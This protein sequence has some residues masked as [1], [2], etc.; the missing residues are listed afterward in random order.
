MRIVWL[1]LAARELLGQDIVFGTVEPAVVEQRFDRLQLKN[2]QRAAVLREIF[3]EAGCTAERWS[4]Q[5]IDSA[6]RPNL[7]CTL[8]GTTDRRVVVSAHYDKVSTGEG[9][10]D[11]WSGASLLPSLFQA[12]STVPRSHTFVFLLTSDEE[13]GLIGSKEF[14]R[15]LTKEQLRTMD[16]DVNIDSID[17]AGPTNVWVSRA[18][19]TLF[20]AAMS[21]AA[22]LGLPM[23]GVNVD[24]G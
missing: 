8:P 10:I 14:V 19:K 6:K 22:A 15:H 4:E 21:V 5:K 2:E 1:L 13:L 23:R 11:N 3:A 20:N 18:D 17:L 12:L 16:G 9:A 24:Q 7:I